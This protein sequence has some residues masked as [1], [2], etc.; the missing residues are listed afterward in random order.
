MC[1]NTPPPVIMA[2][3]DCS[4]VAFSNRCTK[5]IFDK[6]NYGDK[7]NYGHVTAL[8][9]HCGDNVLLKCKD[10]KVEG[11]RLTP[12]SEKQIA[13]LTFGQKY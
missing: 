3:P 12:Q 8:Y 5:Y 1:S 11:L 7:N 6:K 2:R 4:F 13:K 10:V 9:F